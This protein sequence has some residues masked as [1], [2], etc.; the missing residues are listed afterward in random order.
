MVVRLIGIGTSWPSTIGQHAVLIGPP[1]GEL[2]QVVEHALRVGV[3]DVRPVAMHQHAGLVEVVVGIAADVVAPVDDQ[4]A[5]VELAGKPLGQHAAGEAAADD[6]VV[7]GAGAVARGCAGGGGA[8]GFVEVGSGCWVEC[9]HSP[10]QTACPL[11]A[12][13][14]SFGVSRTVGVGTGPTRA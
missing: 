7:E 3:E 11:R 10:R 9:T 8:M 2:R 5:P 1:L 14:G 6:E 4:H 13:Y 12:R